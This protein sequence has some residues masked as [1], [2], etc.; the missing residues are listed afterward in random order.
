MV[1]SAPVA[2]VRS[3]PT[4][5][6]GEYKYDPIQETQIEKGEPVLV[7]EKRGKWFR[8]EAP[9]Q[10]EFSHN[11]KW[12]GYPGWVE[13]NSLTT[14][15][16]QF[17]KIEKLH[18]PAPALR[19][20]ILEKASLHLGSPYLWGGRSLFEP[21]IKNVATGVDCSGLVNWSFRQ[22]GW[23]IPRDAHEQFMRAR[24]V[25]PKD[26][27]PADLLFLAKPEKP[28]K[29]V[30]VLFYEGA[31]TLLEAPQSGEKVRRISSKDRFGKP[32]SEMKNGERIGDR[33]VTFGSFFSEDE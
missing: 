3:Q 8:I 12:E 27:K 23:F 32:I 21:E 24:R 16:L 19:K 13:S 22:V 6:N 5:H 7:L 29:I 17:H 25:E 18:L 4:P 20:K 30:H 31:E 2:N 26:L 15:L 33:I 11:R 10:L 28:E 9:E 14:D 1:V